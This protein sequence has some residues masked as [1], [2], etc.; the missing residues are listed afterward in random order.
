[1]NL[2]VFLRRNL[3]N[4][5][6]ILAAAKTPQVL[7]AQH[8]LHKL[9]WR[10]AFSC[11]GYN[12]AVSHQCNADFQHH[13]SQELL[14]QWEYLTGKF[15]VLLKMFRTLIFAQFTKVT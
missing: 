8:L 7:E 3:D 4:L 9:R 13:G 11:P 5:V 15:L 6:F 12:D 10:L 1:M 14:Q 2:S